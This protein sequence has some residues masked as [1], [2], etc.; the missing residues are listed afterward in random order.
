M[1]G[2]GRLSEIPNSPQTHEILSQKQPAKQ[3]SQP[4]SRDQLWWFMSEIL[5]LRGQGQSG[6][7]QQESVLKTTHN[8]SE[9]IENGIHTTK[10]NKSGYINEKGFGSKSAE[11]FLTSE[12]PF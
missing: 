7:T 8:Q 12:R 3:T 1:G 6:C 4:E 2:G 5:I 9:D 10:E 11:R